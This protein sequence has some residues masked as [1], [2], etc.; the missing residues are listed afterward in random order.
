MWTRKR[1]ILGKRKHTNINV[2]HLGKT[3]G[4]SC[5]ADLSRTISD[6]SAR[7]PPRALSPRHYFH[8][9]K[10]SS[11]SPSSP[12]RVE[13][14][15]GKLQDRQGSSA[16]PPIRESER[17]FKR[18]LCAKR[19]AGEDGFE[20]AGGARHSGRPHMPLALRWAC[21]D[22]SRTGYMWG[23][24]FGNEDEPWCRKIFGGSR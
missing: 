19:K 9:S 7:S 23:L 14:I 21:C 3:P 4:R 2:R 17:L 20:S 24:T 12:R 16:A 8:P 22:G 1:R 13:K 6:P 11:R 18:I 15:A 5:P 10:R